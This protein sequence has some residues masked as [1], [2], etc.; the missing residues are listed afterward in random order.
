MRDS[1]LPI[2]TARDM[3][4]QAWSRRHGRSETPK[5]AAT[6]ARGH[7]DEECETCCPASPMLPV[8]LDLVAEQHD[9]PVRDLAPVIRSVLH[10]RGFFDGGDRGVE[11]ND[12]VEEQVEVVVDV[13]EKLRLDA[14]EEGRWSNAPVTPL[15]FG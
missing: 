13:L 14:L 11:H 2:S 12:D 7:R 3:L 6:A 5:R 15:M 4:D 8:L 9:R 10:E 1:G